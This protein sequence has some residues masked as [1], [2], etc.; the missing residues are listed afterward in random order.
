[1]RVHGEEDTLAID[2]GIEN[3]GWGLSTNE[4]RNLKEGPNKTWVLTDGRILRFY[5]LIAV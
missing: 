1:V 2:W 3:D 4:L 5:Q